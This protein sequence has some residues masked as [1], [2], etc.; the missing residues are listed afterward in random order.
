MTFS[1]GSARRPPDDRQS[2]AHLIE[3]KR[4][5]RTQDQVDIEIIEGLR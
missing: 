1:N 5:G 4:T 2:V 3:S